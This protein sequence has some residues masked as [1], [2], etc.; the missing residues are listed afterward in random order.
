MIARYGQALAFLLTTICAVLLL[1][2]PG[3]DDVKTLQT[4]SHIIARHGPVE[5]Y[6]Q[7]GADYPPLGVLLIAGAVQRAEAQGAAG[8]VGIKG[9]I[10]LFLLLTSLVFYA[11]T[12]N[13]PVT[14]LLQAAF[15]VNSTALGYVDVL[16]APVLLLA[17]AALEARR[18][19]WATTLFLLACLLKWQVIIIAPFLLLYVLGIRRLADW[20]A[21]PWRGLIGG[22]AVPALALM[23]GTVLLFREGVVLSFWY[24]LTKSTYLSGTALNLGWVVTYLLHVADPATYGPLTAGQ[25][26]IITTENAAI[27]GPLKLLF[28]GVF[29][30]ILVWFFTRPKT[31]ANLLLFATLGYLA[32]FTF[33]T[34]VHENH[35]FLAVLLLA[36]LAHRHPAYLLPLAVWAAL[37]N[38]NMIVFY[39]L[40]GRGLSFSPVVGGLDM[41]LPL[42]LMTVLLFVGFFAQVRAAGRAA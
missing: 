28:A 39:G 31:F 19:A 6:I 25:S 23:G 1:N 40:D 29:G 14:T 30:G 20:R 8:S 37:L 16:F 41:T 7:S 33:N 38:I 5:G 34:G 42:A 36:L 22:V 10:L 26:A 12:R 18:F 13:L 27:V 35:L 21:I 4:W 24:A 2:A 32:Y 3:T 9:L 15:L 11:L 17:L